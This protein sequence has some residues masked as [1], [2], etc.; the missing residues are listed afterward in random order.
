MWFKRKLSGLFS[1]LGRSAS[2]YTRE[3]KRW[4]KTRFTAFKIHR[5]NFEETIDN[6]RAKC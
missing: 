3:R 4:L 5:R 2:C 1:I 6:F